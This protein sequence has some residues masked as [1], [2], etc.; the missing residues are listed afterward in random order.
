M[1]RLFLFVLLATIPLPAGHTLIVRG[2]CFYIDGR[3]FPY[4]G[5]SFFSALYN[6]AF[7]ARP[8]YRERLRRLSA[9]ADHWA[10]FEFLALRERHA[11][12]AC[13]E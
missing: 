13:M 1:I 4:T 3:P 10:V 11:P 7:Q 9:D 6:P 5:V 8:L 12:P 2:R